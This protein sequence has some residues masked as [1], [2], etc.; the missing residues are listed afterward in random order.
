MTDFEWEETTDVKRLTVLLAGD[1]EIDPEEF[2]SVVRD[3]VDNPEE[4]SDSEP[5]NYE[6]GYNA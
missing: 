5:R 6:R 1:E 4:T 3:M 2:K